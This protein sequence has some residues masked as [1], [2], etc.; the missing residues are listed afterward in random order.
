MTLPILPFVGVGLQRVL[1]TTRLALRF[2]AQAFA[3]PCAVGGRTTVGVSVP[4]GRY[5]R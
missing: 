4:I 1:T 5:R 3:N 2:D